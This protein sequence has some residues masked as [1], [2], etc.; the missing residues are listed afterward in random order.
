M[1]TLPIKNT[2]ASL[3]C[4]PSGLPDRR[5]TYSLAGW[6]LPALFTCLLAC[7]QPEAKKQDV[8]NQA[9]TADSNW[10]LQ[11]FVKAD[12]DNPILQ[13]G[14]GTFICPVRKQR[15][16]WEEKD[17]FNPAAIIKD[18]KVFLLYRAEDSIGRY[19]GT[20][21][22][23]LAESADGLHFTRHPEPV[24]FPAPD[25]QQK[26]EW[27]GGC[28]DPRVV[29]DSSGSYIMTYTAYD[30]KTARLM[31]ASSKSLLQWT[32]HGPAFAKAFNGKY[33]NTWSKSGSIVA[34]YV[35]GNIIATKI[36]GK[37][38]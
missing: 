2:I 15:V 12:A 8:I 16:K 32:K 21:R 7:Q 38:W 30:G 19:A 9:S 37:Y 4:R 36:N 28:E 26:Y 17:V 24:L 1:L 27:E 29:Q 3:T 22:I 6:C 5:N 25:E 33:L 31:V 34:K 13:T 18:G 11:P 20:S 10:I 14:H 23:G 35:D